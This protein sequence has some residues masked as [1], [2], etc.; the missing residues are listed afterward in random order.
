LRLATIQAGYGTGVLG[1]PLCCD[2]ENRSLTYDLA[3]NV[4]ST[5]DFHN[6]SQYQ[7]FGYDHRSRLV[8]AFTS[9]KSACSS[10]DGSVGAAPYNHT[11]SYDPRGNLTSATGVGSYTYGNTAH[12]GAVTA[13]GSHT[14]SYDQAGNMTTRSIFGQ[15][16]QTLSW[17]AFGRLSQ[18]TQAAAPAQPT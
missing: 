13:A 17:D 11:Y 5:V 6:A 16:P 10:Y 7:C 9:G 3:G 14:F 1:L 4:K 18:V 12:D 15:N 8:S 2:L